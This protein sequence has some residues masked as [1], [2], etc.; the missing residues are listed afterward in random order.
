MDKGT[1]RRYDTLRRLYQYAQEHGD[2]LA[3]MLIRQ[4]IVAM[5][6]QYSVTIR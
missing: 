3:A 2:I 1:E 4:R 6:V 5:M